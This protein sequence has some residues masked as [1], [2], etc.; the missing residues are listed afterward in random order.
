M[1]I[2]RSIYLSAGALLLAIVSTAC[3]GGD[4]GKVLS[5]AGVPDQNA[6]AIARRRSDPGRLRLGGGP[7][8]QRSDLR[9]G[10]PAVLRGLSSFWRYQQCTAA[11]NDLAVQHDGL[12]CDDGHDRL[13]DDRI[14]DGDIGVGAL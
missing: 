5:I 10:Q 2:P 7:E 1:T 13:V 11:S 14:E 3:Q 9:Q 6:S 8:G 12:T 4:K